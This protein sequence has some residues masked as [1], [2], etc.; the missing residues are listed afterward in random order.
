MGLQQL[1]SRLMQVQR[2]VRRGSLLVVTRGPDL[3]RRV[4]DDQLLDKLSKVDHQTYAV[5]LGQHDGLRADDLGATEAVQTESVSE[6]PSAASRIAR[7][8]E[9]H[10]EAEYVVSYCS[11]A[12][13]GKRLVRI[14]ALLT[15]DETEYRGSVD[16]EI[17]AAGFT[18]GCN[19]NRAPTFISVVRA[20]S[21]AP[22]PPPQPATQP[23][24][25]DEPGKPAH[26]PPADGIV[27]PPSTPNYETP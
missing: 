12:R 6:L 27:P 13:A 7:L 22:S 3:A 26:E 4:S 18:A 23:G 20:A 1:E 5:V 16:F 21:A 24:A 25:A 19:P 14:E 9:S 17:D 15:Q 11:P 8:M 10:V 2:P